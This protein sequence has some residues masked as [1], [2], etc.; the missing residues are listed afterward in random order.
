MATAHSH[1]GDDDGVLGTQLDQPGCLRRAVPALAA[2]LADGTVHQQAARTQRDQSRLTQARCRSDRVATVSL[3]LLDLST[4]RSLEAGA[5]D[6]AAPR[7]L[8]KPALPGR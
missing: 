3:E 7:R 4:T 2:A 8:Q 6:A 5:G 1:V